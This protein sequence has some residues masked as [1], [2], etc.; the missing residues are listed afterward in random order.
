MKKRNQKLRMMVAAAIA[1]ATVLAPISGAIAEATTIKA[2]SNVNVRSASGSTSEKV[3]YVYAGEVAN[4]LGTE[5]GWFKIELNGVVG[6]TYNS[7]WTGNTVTAKSNV[8]LRASASNIAQKVGYAVAGTEAAVVGRSGSWLFVD[9]NGERGYSYKTYW[10]LP[11]TLF[12]S[13]PYVNSEISA[14]A[15]VIPDPAAPAPVTPAPPAGQAGDQYKLNVSVPGHMTAA[16]ARSGANATSTLTGGSYY[17]YKIYD[18]MLNIS[19]TKGSAGAWINPA[20]NAGGTVPDPTPVTK[21]TPPTVTR[22]VTQPVPPTQT[23]PITQPK[24][25]TE[26]KPITQPEPPVEITPDPVQP[27]PK[28]VASGDIYT[29]KESVKGY[30][31]AG[32][33]QAEVNSARTVEAGPYHVYKVFSGMYNVSMIKGAP[34]SWINPSR[35]GG[36]TSPGS[37]IPVNAV[38][39]DL[40]IKAAT[41]LLGAPYVYG[42]ESWSEGGFDCS[43]LTQYVYRQAG[44]L[45]PRTATQQWAGISN[46][47]SVPQPGDIIVFSKLG[48]IYH[49]GIYIGDNKMIHSPEPGKVVE[50]KDLTWNYANDRV[51]GFIRPV[52]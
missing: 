7:Y 29:L 35:L 6:Y 4:Y 20:K 19:A 9:V 18:G 15:P 16:D 30:L 3:G 49:V 39:A 51:H 12:Y 1:V 8:N 40:V 41:S 33:A 13:L 28:P 10:D 24:P 37:E 2:K 42:G 43:G 11:D 48:D 23:T 47:V 25:P 52:K 31:T 46:K 5:N 45:I 27:A 34:G 26:T 14:P 21:P 17:V 36:T 22:P 44:I 50:I 32:D 38:T